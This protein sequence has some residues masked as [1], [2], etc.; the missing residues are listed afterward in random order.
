MCFFLEKILQFNELFFP[1][2]SPKR[3]TKKRKK[4]SKLWRCYSD[5]KVQVFGA[6]LWFPKTVFTFLFVWFRCRFKKKNLTAWRVLIRTNYNF[7]DL[8]RLTMSWWKKKKRSFFF[9]HM[10]DWGNLIF[11]TCARSNQLTSGLKRIIIH[12]IPFC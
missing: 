10:S 7:I 5:W 6:L 1:Q 3:H 9:M 2:K 11:N 12:A 8:P 4:E